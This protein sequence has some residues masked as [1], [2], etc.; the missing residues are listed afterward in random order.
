VT[1]SASPIPNAALLLPCKD[2]E[3][4]RDPDNATAEEINVER[5]RVAQAY[6]DCKL[7]HADLATW[8]RGGK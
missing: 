6:A 1:F 4:V 2:P 3:L 5:V 8:A 7:K